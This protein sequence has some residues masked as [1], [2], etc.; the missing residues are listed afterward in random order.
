MPNVRQVKVSANLLG[1]R[2]TERVRQLL[3][4]TGHGHVVRIDARGEECFAKDLFTVVDGHG[5]G[6]IVVSF[7]TSPLG[8]FV[9]LGNLSRTVSQGKRSR[10]VRRVILTASAMATQAPILCTGSVRSP[11]RVHC[12][13]ILAGSRY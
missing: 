1:H 8:K 11:W 6:S 10:R 13:K 2:I 9:A 5:T 12:Y 7:E 4:G 3:D